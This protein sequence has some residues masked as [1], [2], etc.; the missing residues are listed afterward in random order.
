MEIAGGTNLLLSPPSLGRTDPHW[1][2]FCG[3]SVAAFSLPV[4]CPASV[5]HCVYPHPRW[6]LRALKVLQ[7]VCTDRAGSFH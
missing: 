1:V 6:E 4:L 2:F 5:S 7:G 3:V